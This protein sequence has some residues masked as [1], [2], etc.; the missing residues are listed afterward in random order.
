MS[1]SSVDGSVRQ[2]ISRGIIAQH[3]RFYGRGA[4][5]GRTFLVHDDLIVVELCDVFTTVEHTLIERG[6][7]DAVKATRKSFRAAMDDEFIGLVESVTG[8][9]VQ[10]YDSV[11]FI[12]PDRLLEIFALEPQ[13]QTGERT[14][15]EGR[16]DR[17]ELERP[18][19]G[20]AEQ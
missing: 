4:T 5:T 6:Q 7:S 15:R 19:G 13:D 1:E 12:S 8:R 18:I 17:G 11:A 9:K 10:N 14:E 20:L 2:P 16:E 3:K